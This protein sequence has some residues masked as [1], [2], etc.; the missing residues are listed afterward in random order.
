MRILHVIDKLNVDGSKIHGPTRQI[1]RRFQHYGPD[2]EV[3]ICNL[4]GEDIGSEFL[5]KNGLSVLCLGRRKFDPF[6]LKDLLKVIKSWNPSILHLSGYGSW[7]FGRIAGVLT[8]HPV[9]VQEHFIGSKVPYYQIIADWSLQRLQ[10]KG[11]AVSQQVK[12]FMVQKRF[13]DPKIIEVIENGIPLKKFRSVEK[14]DVLALKEKIGIPKAARVV[15][16]IG[17]LATMKG[18][19]YLL[20]AAERILQHERDVVFV[21]IGEGPLRKSLEFEAEQKGLS[22]NV[23]FLGYQENIS[24]FLAM[25]D[26]T[27]ISSIYG[28]GF[29]SVGIESFGAGTPVVITECS[30]VEGIYIDNVNVL[31]VPE[32]NSDSIADAVLKILRDDNLSQHLVA[33]GF[34]SV[35]PYDMPYVAKK[36]INLYENILEL[37]DPPKKYIR[38]HFKSTVYKYSNQIEKGPERM[39]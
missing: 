5:K 34:E 3:L 14:E 13:V 27:V 31:A 38:P 35:D 28:E 6:T 33:N 39:K 19:T 26:I 32:K 37:C 25:F 29:T 22:E 2:Y 16:N 7:N 11:I 23:L 20:A 4:R 17:R 24:T 36:Y 15:G 9:V 18:Q 21:I 8:G 30:C 1:A 10:H 12:E